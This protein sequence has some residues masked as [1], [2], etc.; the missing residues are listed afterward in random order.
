MTPSQ[1]NKVA[2]AAFFYC[3]TFLKMPFRQQPEPHSHTS[4]ASVVTGQG[5]LQKRKPSIELGFVKMGD[6][7]LR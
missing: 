4:Y 3:T 1:Q 5:I 2:K 6:K 7:R